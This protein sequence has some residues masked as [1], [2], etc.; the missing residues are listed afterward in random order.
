MAE[1]A[2]SFPGRWGRFVRERFRPLPHLVLLGLFFAGN[3]GLHTGEIG[4]DALRFAIL[5]LAFLRLRIQDDL[6]DLPGDRV[7]HPQRPLARGL[8]PS[9]EAWIVSFAIAGLEAACALALGQV[10]WVWWLAWFGFSLLMVREFF[11][12]RWLEA[13]PELYALAHTPFAMFAGWFLAGG[14]DVSSVW[15]FGL[16][17]WAA[18]CVFEFSRKTYG[19]DEEPESGVS[20]SKR[21]G[22]RG[23]SALSLIALLGMCLAV[24][25][26]FGDWVSLVF[27][28]PLAAAGQ[29]YATAPTGR[30]ARVF[31][32]CAM[33]SVLVI[34]GVSAWQR[35]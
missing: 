3:R 30:R 20:Y 31:R 21:W 26:A 32:V 8:I 28:L 33:V 10:V 11:A 2:A 35:R 1:A 9:T 29:A 15:R 18:F 17:N 12:G 13:R 23:A 19:R 34:Y 27:V 22:P 14:S 16:A 25:W 7:L 6:K 24:C 4:R 5:F